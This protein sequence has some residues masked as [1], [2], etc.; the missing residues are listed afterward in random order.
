MAL[1]T[2]LSDSALVPKEYRGKPGDILIA[3]GLGHEVGL[4]WAQ[5][6]QSIA[7]IG[8]RPTIWGDAGLG[9]VIQHPDYEWHKETDNAQ[10]QTATCAIK[11]RGLDPVV[12][13]FSQADA[14]RITVWERDAQGNTRQV[15]L[16]DRPVWKAGYGQRMRQMRARWWAMKDSFPDALKGIEGREWVED[17]LSVTREAE[18]PPL[19]DLMPKKPIIPA[20]RSHGERRDESMRQTGG[21]G[22]TEPQNI[23]PSLNQAGVSARGSEPS[24]PSPQG[25]LLLLTP[26]QQ[27]RH[28]LLGRIDELVK[29]KKAKAQW[30]GGVVAQY[31]GGDLATA[32]LDSLLAIH[33]L[34]TGIP[35]PPNKEPHPRKNHVVTFEIGGR[36]YTTAGIEK[37]TLLAIFDAEAKLE[38]IQKGLARTMLVKHFGV[39]HRTDLTEEQAQIYVRK[40]QEAIQ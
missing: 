4:K 22:M 33:D 39:E 36:S 12:R 31:A 21:E 25:T 38:K 23:G 37:T 34:L 10:T 15:R 11:R 30:F 3:I 2:Q 28:A 13:T 40:L 35:D 24:S 7:V 8:G 9:L 18:R 1:A 26:D 14:E 32:S 27:E 5:A 19:E 16:A 6:L 17:D 20:A 29:Q